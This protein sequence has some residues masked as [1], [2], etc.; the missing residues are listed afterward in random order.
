MENLKRLRELAQGAARGVWNSPTL[1]LMLLAGVALARFEPA[2][3]HMVGAYAL[4]GLVALNL[5]LWQGRAAAPDL[6]LPLSFLAGAAWIGWYGNADVVPYLG[7]LFFGAAALAC[8]LQLVLRRPLPFRDETRVA[9]NYLDTGMRGLLALTG[10]LMGLA[11]IPEPRYLA[12]PF[13][14]LLA[15][16]LATPLRRVLYPLALRAAGLEPT[17]GR[18]PGDPAPRS[19]YTPPRAAALLI[20]LLLAAWIGPRLVFTAARYDLTI[21]KPYALPRELLLERRAELDAAIAQPPGSLDAAALTELGLVLHELGLT[22]RAELPRAEQVLKRAMALDPTNAQAVA[23]YG[24]TLA[25]G[26]LHEERPVPRTRLVAE[27]LAQL[28]R[29]VGLA[30]DDPIVRLARASVCLGMPTFIGRLPTARLD[31]EHLL[32]LAR[33]HPRETDPIL[34]FVYQ[35]AGDMYARLGR[36]EQARTYWQAAL[37]ELPER[38]VDY[39]TIRAHLLALDPPEGERHV[40][41]GARGAEARP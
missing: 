25:A 33:T 5:K 20:S 13:T 21:P 3:N 4:V 24:S 19:G 10:M 26:A 41:E 22:D 29:A 9:E 40:A 28:D 15:F 38:S 39:R 2:Y 31:L 23:W 35:R 7:I 17:S 18:V 16:R 37:L 8:A 30:P 32:E 6:A 1:A 34:P 11:W 12:V 36:T 14:L 27:G